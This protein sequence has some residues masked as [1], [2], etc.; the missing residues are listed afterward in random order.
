MPFILMYAEAR[1]PGMSLTDFCPIPN[2][3]FINNCRHTM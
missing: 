1:I 2:N 3:E